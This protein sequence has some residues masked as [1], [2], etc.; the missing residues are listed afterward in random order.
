MLRHFWRAILVAAVFLIAVW[1]NWFDTSTGID[2]DKL[3]QFPLS[4]IRSGWL[5][6][7]SR[8]TFDGIT[9]TAATGGV[10]EVR[11]R[12]VGKSGKRWEVHVSGLDEVWRADLDGNGTQDYVLFGAGPYFNGRITP[13]LS[14]SILLMDRDGVP[15]PF[16]TVAYHEEN[17]AGI[18]HLVDLDH[19]GRAEL[20]ISS[21]DERT[22]DA[23][24]G[25]FCSGHWIT[26]LYR[27]KDFG[28]EEIR[29]TIGGIN[30]PFVQDWTYRG[31]QCREEEPPFLSIEPAILDEHGTSSQ[32][33]VVTTILKSSDGGRF[34]EIDPVAGCRA[35]ST[36][37]VVYDRPQIREIGFP[38]LFTTY[39]A[40]LVD[41]IRRDGARVKLRGIDKWMGNGD[42]SVNL[43]WATAA[44]PL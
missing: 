4:R 35:I 26:Q 6:D 14:M 41:T 38:N 5:R 20:L 17:G 9:A 29:G 24:V 10:Q 33:E 27:F 40:D 43:T 28:A 32:G 42:C 21:Y 37:L 18:K 16:F 30:F 1:G 8:I 11:L 13:P 3:R 23:R 12:G 25:G 31:T 34:F 2:L 19:D 15:V 44:G 39:T 7:G 22:S 36:E